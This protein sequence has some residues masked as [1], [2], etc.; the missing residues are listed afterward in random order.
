V[1]GRKGPRK[2][3][4]EKAAEE[5]LKSMRLKQHEMYNFKIISP[6]DAEK[7]LKD[8]PK[9]WKRLNKPGI[10]TQSDGSLSIAPESD[11]RPAVVIETA[12]D[13]ELAASD[14]LSVEDLV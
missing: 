12:E 2:W 10:I 14:G 13:S 11:P 6:T 1:R 3:D 8:T 7:L 4:N 9:R 5:L